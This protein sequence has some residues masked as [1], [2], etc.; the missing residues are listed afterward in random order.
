MWEIFPYFFQSTKIKEV[1]SNMLKVHGRLTI[2]AVEKPVLLHVEF[3]GPIYFT[4]ETG[5]YTTMGFAATACLQRED[6]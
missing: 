2:R 5:S 6:F 1:G 4:D 3:F